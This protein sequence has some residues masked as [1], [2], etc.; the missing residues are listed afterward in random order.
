MNQRERAICALNG[1]IPDY[2]PHFEMEFVVTERDFEGRTFYGREGEPD[3]TGFSHRELNFHNARLRVDVAKKYEHCV[4][5]SSFTPGCEGRTQQEES[6]EHIKM[7]RDIAGSEFLVLGGDDPT[8]S[9]PG[10]KMMEFVQQLYDEPEKL[11][12]KAQRNVDS[13]AEYFY[14]LKEAGAEGFVLWSDYAFNAGPF[15]SP[16]MFAE[17]VTPYLKQIIEAIKD[18]GCYAIK[19]SD[20][21][22]MPVIDQIVGCR[23]HALHSIDPMAGMDIKEIKES[24]GKEICLIGNVDCSLMHVGKSQEIRESAEYAMSYGKP[25]GGYIFSSS[26]CIFRG[27]PIQSYDIIHDIWGNS[28]SYAT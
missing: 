14:R 19:H 24:Y 15:L 1:G 20:G 26:N 4:I 17:F 5:L 10:S 13:V 22:L 9:I 2:V 16:S 7:L 25:E 23:P 11:K 18:M 8:F 12:E 21:N 6:E 27:M 3:R 28:R